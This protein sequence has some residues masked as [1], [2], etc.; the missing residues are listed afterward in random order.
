MVTCD[1]PGGQAVVQLLS[2]VL[3]CFLCHD[4]KVQDEHDHHA[5][6]ILHWHHIHHTPET[7]TCRMDHKIQLYVVENSKLQTLEELFGEKL[8]ELVLNKQNTFSIL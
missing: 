2:L 8:N 5:I 7:L 4:L 6:L 1:K 3:E